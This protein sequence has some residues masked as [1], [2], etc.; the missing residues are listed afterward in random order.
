MVAYILYNIYLY[1][2]IKVKACLEVNQIYWPL[3]CGWIII[4]FTGSYNGVGMYMKRKTLVSLYIK[5]I[6]FMF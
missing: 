2:P 4:E 1:L 6:Q 5:Y 3:G